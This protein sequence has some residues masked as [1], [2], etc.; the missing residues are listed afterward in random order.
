MAEEVRAQM[1]N[2]GDN[3]VSSLQ[4]AGL[5]DEEMKIGATPGE[6]R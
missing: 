4:G 6:V 1:Q 2:E 3:I 5:C